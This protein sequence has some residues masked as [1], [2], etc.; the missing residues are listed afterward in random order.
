MSVGVYY[1]KPHTN[2]FQP[3]PYRREVQKVKRQLFGPYDAEATQRFVSQELEKRIVTQTER[4]NFDFVND[5]PLSPNGKYDW[6]PASP[7]VKCS[8]PMKRRPSKDLEFD[9]HDLYCLP[10]NICHLKIEKTAV[11]EEKTPP[12]NSHKTQSLITDFMQFK[13]SSGLEMPKKS[14]TGGRP[15]KIPRMAD[16]LTS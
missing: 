13:K 7:A 15:T 5:K 14:K 10:E 8:R 3:K 11:E 1:N 9:N 6:R 2:L 16:E 12:K 4:W